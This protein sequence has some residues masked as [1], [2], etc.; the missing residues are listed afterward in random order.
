[1]YTPTVWFLKQW[2]S[3]ILENFAYYNVVSLC[4]HNLRHVEGN[5]F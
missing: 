2:K 1:M 5:M 4:K 3:C